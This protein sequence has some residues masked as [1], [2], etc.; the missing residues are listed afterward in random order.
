ML[1]KFVRR[2]QMAVCGLCMLVWWYPIHTVG[3]FSV[4]VLGVVF[5]S[6]IS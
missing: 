2:I 4:E 6:I 5:K 3:N 1:L